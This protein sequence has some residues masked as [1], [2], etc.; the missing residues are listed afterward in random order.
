M[1]ATTTIDL[2][3]NPD[4]VDTRYGFKVLYQSS[5]TIDPDHEIS[6]SAIIVRC[7]DRRCTED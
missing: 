7:D 6:A 2:S 5:L 1:N 3:V 4:F